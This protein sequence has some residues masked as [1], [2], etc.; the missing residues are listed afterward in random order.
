MGPV[1]DFLEN[2]KAQQEW[3][4]RV[5]EVEKWVLSTETIGFLQT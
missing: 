5:Y 2:S 3:V 4:M 1:G